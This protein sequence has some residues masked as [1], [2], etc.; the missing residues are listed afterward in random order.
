MGGKGAAG[1]QQPLVFG[2]G[3]GGGGGGGR[4]DYSGG[5]MNV[6]VWNPGGG[7]VPSYEKGGGRMGPQ[8][9]SRGSNNDKPGRQYGGG[10]GGEGLEGLPVAART[11]GALL[12]AMAGGVAAGGPGAAYGGYKGYQSGKEGWIGDTFDA[13]KNEAARDRMESKGISRKDTALASKHGIANSYASSLLEE[14]EDY[15]SI[16]GEIF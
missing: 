6:G 10:G 16:T 14:G 2:Q 5:R 7:K 3:R 4:G 13:R 15:D 11:F 1:A 12:G 9:E 8:G